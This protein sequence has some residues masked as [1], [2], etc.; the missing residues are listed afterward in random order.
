MAANRMLKRGM[1]LRVDFLD[2]CE[3]N[4]N[5]FVCR[6]TG[7]LVRVRPDHIVID[8]WETISPKASRSEHRQNTKTYTILRSAIKAISTPIEWA[9]VRGW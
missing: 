4:D 9:D 3:D 5:P 6:V 1:T 7:S 8:C 2:H